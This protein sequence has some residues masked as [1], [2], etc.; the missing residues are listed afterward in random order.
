M[1]FSSVLVMLVCMTSILRADPPDVKIDKVLVPS[2]QFASF[3]PAD[4]VVDA[5]YIKNGH[6]VDPFPIALL[7][8]DK[9]ALRNFVFDTRALP[10]KLYH[11]HGVFSNAKGEL[12]WK[13]FAVQVGKAPDPVIP[14]N[15]PNPPGPVPVDGA[16]GLSKAAREG[17]TSLTGL[18]A[19]TRMVGIKAL[20]SF[21]RSHASA[22]AAGGAGLQGGSFSA[23]VAVEEWAQGQTNAIA[24]LSGEKWVPWGKVVTERFNVLFQDGKLKTKADYVAA[25]NE[26]AA[27]LD[28]GQ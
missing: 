12:T 14:P 20:A 1:R 24:D 26:I 15:P 5:K 19:A 9:K 4:D 27:G 13:Q 25:F 18:D 7:T 8:D 23:K 28:Q 2:G 16:L 3:K 21:N 6:D 10:E 17:L 22:V 11:F